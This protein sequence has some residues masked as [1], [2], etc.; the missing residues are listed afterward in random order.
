M[1]GSAIAQR[2]Q[3]NR[4][5]ITEVYG[6]K[7]PLVESVVSHSFSFRSLVAVAVATVTAAYILSV[8]AGEKFAADWFCYDFSVVFV[9]GLN[10][11]PYSTWA[12][13]DTDFFWPAE[14]L[15]LK[16][17]NQP[18]RVLMFGYNATVGAFMD[19]TSRDKLHH[20]AEQL[21]TELHADRNV[22]HS[23]RSAMY[24]LSTT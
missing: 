9:H 3:V 15:P 22:S 21:A 18:I 10:G 20:H 2:L 24:E 14:L 1:A 12:T 23:R 17:R 4:F 16:P 7:D 5:G 6:C 19:G 8:S 11:H 13:K